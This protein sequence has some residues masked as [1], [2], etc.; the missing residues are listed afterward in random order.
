IEDWRHEYNHFRPH[1][2]L[3]GMTPQ[4]MVEMYQKGARISNL[5]CLIIG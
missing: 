5:P 4:E 2:S 3:N 1:S